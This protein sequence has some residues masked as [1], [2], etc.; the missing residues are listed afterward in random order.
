M[1]QIKIY[2]GIKCLQCRTCYN[3]NVAYCSFHQKPV[4]QN[5]KA[6][7]CCCFFKQVCIHHMSRMKHWWST[8]NMNNLGNF[9]EIRN[10]ARFAEFQKIGKF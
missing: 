8:Q 5:P 7:L 10:T 3:I 1:N 9:P 4:R 6:F 2:S